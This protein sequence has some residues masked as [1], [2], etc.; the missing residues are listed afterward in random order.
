[1]FSHS[2]KRR[3]ASNRGKDIG[4]RNPVYEGARDSPQLD[5]PVYMEIDDSRL[6]N[7]NN[8]PLDNNT[9]YF[10]LRDVYQNNYET[11]DFTYSE[12]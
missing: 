9:D 10:A 5:E 12:A 7:N 1:M 2:A 6:R 3:T 4:Y 11:I 8:L